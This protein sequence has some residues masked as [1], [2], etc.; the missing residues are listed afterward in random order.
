MQC[1]SHST[2]SNSFSESHV[3]L[4]VRYSLPSALAFMF[5][6]SW[7]DSYVTNMLDSD[8]AEF[9]AILR[10]DFLPSTLEDLE[11]SRDLPFLKNLHRDNKRQNHMVPSKAGQIR[12]GLEN[13]NGSPPDV[14]DSSPAGCKIS[15]SDS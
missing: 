5:R 1:I 3:V 2:F 13:L 9:N 7:I 6:P 15:L 10:A 8:L 12:E 11:T 14:Q 4:T